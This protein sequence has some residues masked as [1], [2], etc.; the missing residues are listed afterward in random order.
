MNIN[1]INNKF[2]QLKYII[3]NDTDVLIV[4]ET[5]LDSSFPSGQ[6]SIDGSAKPFRRDR[7]K[8]GGDV[9]I[10]VRDDI[11]SKEIKVN[12]LPH[13]VE[14]LF[15]EL[16]IRKWLLVHCYHPPSQNDD[17]YFCNLSKILNSLKSNYK[18]FL[19]IG[20]FNS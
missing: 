8:N 4:N 11:P 15:I 17:Y 6:S 7:N 5:K 18:K 20:D 12:F 19:L 14:C 3:K 1:A 9:M 13:D 10:F 16:N 2:E